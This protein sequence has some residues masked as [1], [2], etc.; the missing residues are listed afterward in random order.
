MVLHLA[1]QLQL[2]HAPARC[3]GCCHCSS[4]CSGLPAPGESALQREAWQDTDGC[5]C[6]LGQ[7]EAGDQKQQ[8]GVLSVTQ[9]VLAYRRAAVAVATGASPQVY[10]VFAV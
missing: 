8:T 9:S 6:R 1:Q 4:C 7:S 2:L 10:T 5:V 3:C